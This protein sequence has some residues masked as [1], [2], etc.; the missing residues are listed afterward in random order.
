VKRLTPS[1]GEPSA[2]R[3]NRHWIGTSLGLTSRTL[4]K[5]VLVQA[6]M[7]AQKTRSITTDD[8]RAMSDAAAGRRI[9]HCGHLA[10]E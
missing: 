4:L 10:A 5:F 8:D 6:G 1:S 2:W 7:A 3:A 9:A